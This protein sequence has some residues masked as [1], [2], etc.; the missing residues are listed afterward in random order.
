MAPPAGAQADVDCGQFQW[1]EDAQPYL[2]PGDPH[3][4]DRDGDGSACDTLPRRGS[5]TPAPTPTA[6]PAAAPDPIML[7]NPA[8]QPG[9]CTE[10]P[11]PAADSSTAAPRRVQQIPRTGPEDAVVL[12][13][14][15]GAGAFLFVG[16]Y[17]ITA[18]ADLQRR[19][20]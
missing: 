12:W 1:W 19:R 9:L 5:A 15:L 16:G 14:L 6:P 11:T 20:T 18:A 7:A 3:D 10:R 13:S 8:C 2:L 17:F 4:L